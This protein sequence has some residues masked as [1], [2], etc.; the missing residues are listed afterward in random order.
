MR[1]LSTKIHGVLDY[2]VG[3]VLI[4]IPWLLHFAGPNAAT[5]MMVGSGGV[6]IIYSLFTD[7]E[8]GAV[9]AIPMSSHLMLDL[10]SGVFLAVSPWLFGFSTYMYLPHLVFGLLEII[11]S[12]ITRK[13][14]DEKLA[15]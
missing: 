10:L 12:L 4:L 11:V 3:I 2:L 14:S 15:A 13:V 9:R 5:Y 1:V 7:Y 6:A 8:W